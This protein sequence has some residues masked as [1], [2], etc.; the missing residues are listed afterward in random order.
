MKIVEARITDTRGRSLGVID[1][2]VRREA[3]TFY[4]VVTTAA[5]AM[6]TYEVV[7]QV[8]LAADQYQVK[9]ASAASRE[10]DRWRA[11][12]KSFKFAV[13]GDTESRPWWEFNLLS[14]K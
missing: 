12:P 14:P 1:Q 13:Y 4:V 11:D 2:T 8:H 10:V 7:C 9:I 5:A 6:D 3:N